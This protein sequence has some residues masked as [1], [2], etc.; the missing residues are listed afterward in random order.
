MAA[1][2]GIWSVVTSHGLPGSVTT[3]PGGLKPRVSPRQP[4]GTTT[5]PGRLV[6]WPDISGDTLE[7]LEHENAHGFVLAPLEQAMGHFVVTEHVQ[8]DAVEP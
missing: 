8:T 5:I 7:P 6:L 4:I 1:R 3:T 2:F